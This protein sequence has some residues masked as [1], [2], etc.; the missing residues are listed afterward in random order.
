MS[1]I[2]NFPCESC[3]APA[4]VPCPPECPGIGDDDWGVS[5]EAEGTGTLAFDNEPAEWVDDELETPIL[6]RQI[7]FR[8]ACHLPFAG[9][10]STDPPYFGKETDQE[11]WLGE[12]AVWLARYA[13]IATVQTDELSVQARQRIGLQ[14]E[15]D[16]LRQF[17]GEAITEKL[18]ALK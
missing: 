17:L 18:E 9:L 7:L 4:G 12:F 15:K 13:Q 1:A 6:A 10:V 3:G 5:Y 8:A 2:D 16:V 14:I 11:Q